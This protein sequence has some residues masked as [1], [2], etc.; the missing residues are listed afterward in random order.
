MTVIIVLAY[1]CLLIVIGWFAHRRV[2]SST[3]QYF[4]AGR[5]IGTFVNSWA[6]LASLTSGST[7]L[8][9]TGT[10]LA[11]GFPYAAALTSAATVGLLI[12]SLLVARP[13][14]A[15]GKYTVPDYFRAR[16][17]NR[18]LNWMVP[19]VILVASMGYL[20]AQLKA[21]SIVAAGL[22]DWNY[23]TA[24]WSIGLIFLI[25]VSIGGFLSVTWNDVFQGILMVAM[26]VGLMVAALSAMD[27][28]GAAFTSATAAF[29][30]LGGVAASLPLPSYIGAFVTWATAISVL[31][32]VIMRVYSSKNVRSARRALSGATVLY[33][34]MALLLTVIGVPAAAE[35]LTDIDLSNPD[36]IL[37][38][39][40][41]RV[42]GPLG[43]GL[44]AAALLAAIMSTT[45]GL[46]MAC[47]AA[48][49]HDIYSALLRP[50]APERRVVRVAMGATWLIGLA[51]IVL[52]LNPPEFIIVLSTAS[53]ALL[54]S[55]FFAPLILGIWWSH[56][57][58]IGATWGV[59]TGGAV[60]GI[61]FL[62]FDMPTSSEVLTG[63]PASFLAT[64]L[65]S[66][67]HGKRA[68]Q[69]HPMSPDPAG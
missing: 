15:L 18:W 37:L 9:L 49:G 19:I 57:T 14:R 51:C 44:F 2:S 40:V 32:H 3:D 12:A 45:A 22:L 69:P 28:F 53:V 5:T 25:Y 20:V 24:L 26:I 68:R 30:G 60:F 23:E 21:A 31:P 33:V 52:A 6:F 17:T 38:S 1:F 54:A 7:M 11:L 34:V 4:V 35:L 41:D 65:V 29:P 36:Q 16:F 43:Q 58:S 13:L 47:N 56:T 39:L 10:A 27:G 67:V 59:L 66:I 61:A 8:A 62:A 48:A 46:L 50:N 55:A 63:V 42:F 64:I